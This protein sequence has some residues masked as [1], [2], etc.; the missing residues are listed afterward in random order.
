MRLINALFPLLYHGENTIKGRAVMMLGLAVARLAQGGMEEA[1]NVVRRLM[2]NLNDESGSIGWGSPEAMG[3]ILARHEG[4][5]R[6]YVHILASYTRPDGNYLENEVLQRG[7]L[8]ALSRVSKSNPE[9][10]RKTDP[11]VLPYLDSSDPAVRGLAAGLL[12]ELR[13]KRGCETLARL[14]R[15]DAEYEPV[16]GGGSNR[17]VRD[18]AREALA[19]IG[20]LQGVEKIRRKGTPSPRKP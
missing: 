14:A 12:G 13:E 8:W 1:R 11:L 9:L 16:L 15:D 3:E 18:A 19:K 6:E 10:V 4:L 2:W 17:R 7:V 5:A 20:C